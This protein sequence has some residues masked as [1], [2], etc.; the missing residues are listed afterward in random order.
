M[1]L[2]CAFFLWYKY[3][4]DFKE[5]DWGIEHYLHHLNNI[6]VRIVQVVNSGLGDKMDLDRSCRFCRRGREED[7][8]VYKGVINVPK[9]FHCV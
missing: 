1:F 5:L 9:V 7:N 6:H 3:F 4:S 8:Y 2:C